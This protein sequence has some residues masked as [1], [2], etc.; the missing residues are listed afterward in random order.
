IQ[1]VRIQSVEEQ[2]MQSTERARSL[3]LTH[4]I[5]QSNQIRGLLLEFGIVIPQ[6]INS[7]RRNL[8]MILEDAENDLPDSF[9]QIVMSL[10]EHLEAQ[11]EHA[12]AI[13]SSLK[14]TIESNQVCQKLMKLEGVGPIGALGLSLRLGKGEHYSNGRNAAASIG[15]TP[16]QHSS[17]GKEHIGHISKQCAD[18]RLRATLYQ[19]ALSVVSLVVNRPP[20]THKEQWLKAL[21]ARRGKKVA[22]IALANKT[23]RTAFAIL[24]SD[25]EYEPEVIV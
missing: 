14:G 18:K 21:I 22:A 25:S 20:K 2:A 3:A 4:V 8:P 1:S 23:V 16:K 17:G 11:I 7:L 10:W 13:T 5:A 15:L 24:K 6:G 19:G 9:R 12:D